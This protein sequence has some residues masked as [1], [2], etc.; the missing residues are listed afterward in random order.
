M[1]RAGEAGVSKHEA[2]LPD[3][4]VWPQTKCATIIPNQAGAG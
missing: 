2:G 3:I 4:S 1:L